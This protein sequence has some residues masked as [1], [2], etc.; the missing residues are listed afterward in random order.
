ME[1]LQH[2]HEI[3]QEA[4]QVLRKEGPFIAQHSLTHFWLSSEELKFCWDYL[5]SFSSLDEKEKEKR[6]EKILKMPFSSSWLVHLSDSLSLSTYEESFHTLSQNPLLIPENWCHRVER[7]GGDSYLKKAKVPFFQDLGKLESYEFKKNKKFFKFQNFD[8]F[9][10]DRL[11]ISLNFEE[12]EELG[13]SF[14]HSHRKAGPLFF[15]S[16]MFLKPSFWSEAWGHHM[17]WIEALD[18][19]WTHE[20]LCV[21][22]KVQDGLVVWVR[23]PA[24][25]RLPKFQGRL[26]QLEEVILTR[27]TRKIPLGELTVLENL[28]PVSLFPVYER[29]SGPKKL[30]SLKPMKGVW[31]DSVEASGRL[32]W[33]GRFHHQQNI[34][35][36]MMV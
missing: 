29:P 36:E 24:C 16:K 6:R 1:F 22:Q 23:L 17:V 32:D 13:I 9:S 30:S 34:L 25:C 15:W 2:D 21:I 4:F 12:L 3:Q 19:F 14:V 8:T 5:F 26:R 35:K 18:F 20:N 10:T 28:K 27:L 7:Q 33:Q 31:W 11:I